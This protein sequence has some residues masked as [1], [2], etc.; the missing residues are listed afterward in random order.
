MKSVL[1]LAVIFLL[2]AVVQCEFIPSEMN[3]DLRKQVVAADTPEKTWALI[4]QGKSL[5]R[6]QAPPA[7]C[8]SPV[9]ENIYVRHFV[10]AVA[11]N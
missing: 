11:K 3:E 8:V 1:S 2:F 9:S 5:A 6:A 7:A 10:W 4:E